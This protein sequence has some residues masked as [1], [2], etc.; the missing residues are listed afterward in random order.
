MADA[1]ELKRVAFSPGEFAKLFGKSKTWGYRQIYAG[2][3]K[4]I[5]EF[6]RT[7][8]AAAEVESILRTAGIFDGAKPKPVKTKREIEALAP[9]LPNAW[10]SFLAAR[11]QQNPPTK[12]TKT[13][14]APQKWPSSPS[15]RQAA[16]ARLS[17]RKK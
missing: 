14:S 11:R 4:A 5:T 16:L 15:T 3:V 12:P 7:L 1:S 10:R 8:I 9:Q 17:S 6:G 13:F 2:K